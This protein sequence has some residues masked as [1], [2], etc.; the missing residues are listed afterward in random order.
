MPDIFASAARNIFDE[1]AQAMRIA[2]DGAPAEALN[3]KP[4]GDDTNSITVLAVH[5]MHSTRSWLS[6][7]TG[8]PL[9]AR[10]RDDEF[11]ATM[12][13]AAALLAFFDGM[14]ADCDRILDEANVPTGRRRRRR[15]ARP[16]PYARRRRCLPRGRSCMRSSTWASTPARFSSRGSSSTRAGSRPNHRDVKH[17]GTSSP[18]ADTTSPGAALQYVDEPDEGDI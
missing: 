3:R 1:V 9:P 5:A 2:I 17:S 13:D 14:V 8:A 18:S 4:G 15:T 11:V 10:N 12:P 16:Q 7:A 6:V